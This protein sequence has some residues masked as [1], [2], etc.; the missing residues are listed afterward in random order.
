MKNKFFLGLFCF[1]SLSV[2]SQGS[3]RFTENT[4]LNTSLNLRG[5]KT[6]NSNQIDG[7]LYLFPNWVNNS[8]LIPKKGQS[9]QISNLNYNLSTKKL[10][11][12]ISKD[13]VFQLE[14]QQFDY[15]VQSN[16]KYKVINDGA[17]NGLFLEMVN[18]EKIKLFK[19]TRVIV[20]E[21]VLNPM[22]HEKFEEDKYLQKPVYY[23]LVSGKYEQAKLG[24]KTILKYM[25]DKEDIIKTFVSK[26]KLSYSSEADVS[27]I[28][29]HY[30]SL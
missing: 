20:D 11:A 23:F 21:G 6:S 25:N 10:E 5:K 2:F 18:G 22:T 28:L 17:I 29:N 15:L 7:S 27:T 19:E 26:N 30:N 13:S 9:L 12:L 24:K 3:L 14:I 1:F 8:I 16:K 4:A